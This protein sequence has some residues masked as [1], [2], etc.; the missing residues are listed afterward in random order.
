M[1]VLRDS[2]GSLF[3]GTCYMYARLSPGRRQLYRA[4]QSPSV[5]IEKEAYHAARH[6]YPWNREQASP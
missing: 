6:L 3:A 2:K 5:P 4:A 1:L